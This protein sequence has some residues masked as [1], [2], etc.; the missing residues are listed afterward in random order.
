[1]RDLTGVQL[2]HNNK[3]HVRYDCLLD[4]KQWLYCQ[5][6]IA[7]YEKS[8]VAALHVAVFFQLIMYANVKTTKRYYCI[9]LRVCCQAANKGT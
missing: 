3:A 2:H 5:R 9:S 1:M 7:L 8:W 4:T 6:C